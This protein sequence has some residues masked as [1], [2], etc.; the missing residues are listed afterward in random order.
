M[1]RERSIE[2]R[3]EMHRPAGQALCFCQLCGPKVG[4]IHEVYPLTDVSFI[5]VKPCQIQYYGCCGSENPDSMVLRLS[6]LRGEARA[7]IDA[8]KNAEDFVRRVHEQKKQQETNSSVEIPPDV[9]QAYNSYMSAK[10]FDGCLLGSM[11][12]SPT[13]Q[14][15]GNPAPGGVKDLSTQ[16]A[17]LKAFNDQGVLTDEEFAAAKA[18]LMA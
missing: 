18:K 17:E 12:A 10:F 16:I 4:G 13:P 2:Y 5:N 11:A 14:V 15:T 3:V 1:V 9:M 6:S 7:V 8:P